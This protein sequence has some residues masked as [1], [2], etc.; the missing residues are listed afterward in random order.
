MYVVSLN[1]FLCAFM[2]FVFP[3]NT[4]LW[5]KQ[6][7]YC[8][9]PDKIYPA[10]IPGKPHVYST[11]E[12]MTSADKV[13]IFQYT[14]VQETGE[15]PDGEVTNQSYDEWEPFLKTSD[16]VIMPLIERPG[17][18]ILLR[19]TEDQSPV[20]GVLVKYPEINSQFSPTT[21]CYQALIDGENTVAQVYHMDVLSFLIP[22]GAILYLKLDSYTPTKKGR[23]I[24]VRL[25]VPNVSVPVQGKVYVSALRRGLSERSGMGS[26]SRGSITLEVNPWDLIPEQQWNGDK[27]ILDKWF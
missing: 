3:D 17:A 1:A 15:F 9:R 24:A 23:F 21:G 12:V 22:V 6:S 20:I 25:N 8:L 4:C 7:P 27:S 13:Q 14:R 18:C 16:L 26:Q 5:Y 10:H 11:V 2:I 19:L